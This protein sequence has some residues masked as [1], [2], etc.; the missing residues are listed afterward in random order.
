[1]GNLVLAD[2]VGRSKVMTLQPKRA[3][4]A[5]ETAPIDALLARFA[6]DNAIDAATISRAL[7][8]AEASGERID[9]V[10]IKLG[11][12]EEKAVAEAWARQ[13]Q[14]P[15]LR[16]DELPKEPILPNVLPARFLR[17]AQVLPIAVDG[18]WLTIAVVDPLDHHA[19]RAIGER[20]GLSVRTSLTTHSEFA[21][22]F[23]KLY[24]VQ[25][26]SAENEPGDSA[27]TAGDLQRLQDLAT[28]APAIRF[29]HSIIE[30]AVELRASDIHL[31]TSRNGTRLRYRVDGM[32]KDYEPPPVHLYSSLISR[33]KVLADIDISESRLPQDGR[34]RYGAS[35]RE[36]D[37]RIA[38]MPHLEGEGAVIRILD[39]KAVKLD[40]PELGFQPATQSALLR[41]L[42]EPH[43][44]FL[45][46]GPTGSGKTT[47]LYAAL[48]HLVQPERNVVSVE[49]PVEYQLDG[50]A[51]IQVQR[52]IG[53]DF[54]AVLRAVLRQDPDIIMVGEIRDAET[55]SIAN[56]AALTG[57]FV[58]ATLHTNSAAA[59]LPRLIDMG[60]EPYLLSSTIRGIVAQRL[61]RALCPHCSKP[62]DPEDRATS[63]RLKHLLSSAPPLEAGKHVYRPVGCEKCGQTG[64]LGRFAIAEFLEV[65]DGIRDA[66]LQRA[67]AM[68]IDR[69]ARASG[70]KSLSQAG[71]EM[72]LSSRTSLAELI[73]ATGEEYSP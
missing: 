44:I 36:I 48:R 72:M 67:D 41:I 18:T 33:L 70:T 57:H 7:Q 51:Q 32:L 49:D 22:A 8:A 3:S 38:T 15:K 61:V 16:P 62:I 30:R 29:I 35:G 73:R 24:G 20:T 31:T 34:I 2:F 63:S 46:T 56:Q 37:L 6:A 47:T 19:S 25:D 1:L 53:L 71:V 58:L 69:I 60:L 40:L 59:S 28:D 23:R 27:S 66:I 4:V 50:V 21:A 68:K 5:T 17:H 55:A 11:L 9:R 54:P 39:R 14:I 43:G 42:N 65:T 26:S 10:L 52:K 45:V 12:A 64:Y 13:L